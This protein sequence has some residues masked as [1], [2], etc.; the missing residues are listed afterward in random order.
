MLLDASTSGP[1]FTDRS[2]LHDFL[3]A[4]GVDL[5]LRERFLNHDAFRDLVADDGSNKRAAALEMARQREFVA[6]MQAFQAQCPAAVPVVFKGQALAYQ[7]YEHPWLRP[8]GDIDALADPDKVENVARVLGQSGYVQA[9]AIDGGLVLKQ[10]TFS[11]NHHGISHIWDLHWAISNR[12]LFADRL[13]YADLIETGERARAGDTSFIVPSKVNS[14]LIAC[15]HLIGHH[16]ADIRL[17]WLYD[18]HL[19]AHA[20]TESR[21]QDFVDAAGSRAEIRSACHAALA[22]TQR[23]MPAARTQALM[24]SLDPGSGSRVYLDQRRIS[25][26]WADARSVGH[27]NRLHWVRQHLFPS[28]SYMM[29]RFGIRRRWQLPLWYGIRFARAVPKLFRRG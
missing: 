13:S 18:I 22:T 25:R 16:A 26:L 17:I 4:H 6:V 23:Y 8:R 12:P 1:G 28:R 14:L 19:L 9:N 15:L 21:L 10:T 2:V 29:K 27:A 11:K 5:C 20:L 24:S 3:H 7:I